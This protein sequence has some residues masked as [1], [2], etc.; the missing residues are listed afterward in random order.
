MA[1][2]HKRSI[3][4]G[5][6]MG[7]TL[8]LLMV[9][10]TEPVATAQANSAAGEQTARKDRRVQVHVKAVTTDG[11]ALPSGSTVE[12]SGTETACGPLSTNDARATLD[13]KGEAVLR[14]LPGC[15]VAVKVNLAQYL[16]VRKV[17]D[18]GA[19]KPCAEGGGACETVSLVL[20]P[21]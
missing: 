16:P 6:L 1:T 14:D 15:R 5:R 20:D 10:G 2:K 12:I 7:V 8:L 19:S 13:D 21:Q 4:T 18:L 11:K 17:V 3:G 9:A